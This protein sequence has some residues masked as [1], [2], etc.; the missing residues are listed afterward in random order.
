VVNLYSK[1][2]AIMLLWGWTIIILK[3]S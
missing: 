1:L 2:A 3:N